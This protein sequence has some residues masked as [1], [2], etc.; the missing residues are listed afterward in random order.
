M[1]VKDM[2]IQKYMKAKRL[3]ISRDAWDS[4]TW[5]GFYLHNSNDPI[6]LLTDETLYSKANIYYNTIKV[7]ILSAL[8]D[9][10]E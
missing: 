8:K 9:E 7:L 1:K 10:R 5:A 4:V 3:G 6:K 2:Y